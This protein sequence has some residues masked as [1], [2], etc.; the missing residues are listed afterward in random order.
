[1]TEE[2][3]SKLVELLREIKSSDLLPPKMPFEV[4]REIVS[5]VPAPTVEVLISRND[6]DF[7]LTERND[8]YWQGWHIP[9]GYLLAKETI[10]DACNRLAKKELGMGVNFEKILFLYPWSNH[11]YSNALSIVCLC[12]PLGETEMGKYFLEIP[13]TTIEEHKDFLKR[14]LNNERKI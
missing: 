11:P 8:K 12:H 9:G 4:W 2:N 14:F 6:K 10:E 1:M 7:L 5:L 13:E 3:I